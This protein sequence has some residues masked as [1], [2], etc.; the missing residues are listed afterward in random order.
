MDCYSTVLA[1]RWLFSSLFA[2]LAVL[3][4]AF[5]AAKKVAYSA[6][7]FFFKP[8]VAVGAGPKTLA[9]FFFERH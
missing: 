1:I 5:L 8:F 2:G 6:L 4:P 7:A 3:L 9:V